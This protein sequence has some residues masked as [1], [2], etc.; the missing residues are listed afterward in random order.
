LTKHI[1]YSACRLLDINAAVPRI[2]IVSCGKAKQS[3]PGLASELYTSPLFQKSFRIASQCCDR[4]YVLSAKHG[5][6]AS[7]MPLESYELSLRSLSQDARKV[8]GEQ[9][10]KSIDQASKA[11]DEILVFAG[12]EYKRAFQPFLTG[13]ARLCDPLSGLGLG[14]RLSLLTRLE[15]ILARGHL[16]IRLY[17]ALET[18]G[19]QGNRLPLEE[20][21]AERMIPTRG[22][23]IF[24]DASED[25][26]LA[27]SQPRVVRIGTHAVSRGATSTLRTRLR[28]HLGTARGGGSHRSSIFRLHMGNSFIQQHSLRGFGEWGQG[29]T[30]NQETRTAEAELESTVSSAMRQLLVS[31]IPV[32][33]EASPR[34][35]RALMERA[36]IG[37]FT[38]GADYLEPP[39]PEWLGQNSTRSEIRE[40]GLW[41][42]QH[43]G[44]KA[45]M[46]IVKLAL[47]KLAL[48][49]PEPRH[50]N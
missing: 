15:R 18:A 24:S 42:L 21:L 2:G 26:I 7:D 8:W 3:F 14:K 34:S 16:A 32:D 47:D 9:T 49:A 40:S 25:S 5:L 45:D 48:Y 30:A 37:L 4:V 38:E 22:V 44:S 23:Y 50:C 19:L 46:K 11:S 41:N 35:L 28:T 31:V 13:G 10:A 43:S 12:E 29:M 27:P 36:M 6:I 1:P 39:T 33:D 20:Y 17:K